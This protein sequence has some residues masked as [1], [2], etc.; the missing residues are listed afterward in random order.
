MTAS[1]MYAVHCLLLIDPTWCE[2]YLRSKIITIEVAEIGTLQK[3]VLFQIDEV[4]VSK[5]QKEKKIGHRRVDATT[6]QTTYKKVCKLGVWKLLNMIRTL[7]P[8]TAVIHHTS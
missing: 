2:F 4:V 6:G 3:C 5:P 7:L 1:T 8:V